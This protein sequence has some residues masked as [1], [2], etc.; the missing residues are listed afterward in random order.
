M[1]DFRWTDTGTTATDVTGK[2]ASRPTVRQQQATDQF[3]QQSDAAKDHE[4]NRHQE[5]HRMEERSR[6]EGGGS[7]RESDT[8]RNTR[9]TNRL[10]LVSYNIRHGRGM[11][12]QVNLSRTGDVLSRLDA[13]II[14]L[15][16]VDFRADRSGGVNQVVALGQQLQMYPAFAPFMEFQGGQYGIAILS[17]LPVVDSWTIPLPEGREPRAAVAIK[18]QLPDGQRVIAISVHFDWIGDDTARFAQATELL[19]VIGSYPEPVIVLGDYNDEPES[20][21]LD[22]FRQSGI[23]ADDTGATFRSDRL[24][25]RLDYITLFPRLFIE[26]SNPALS[27]TTESLVSWTV[28]A[29]RMISEPFASDHL[30]IVSEVDLDFSKTRG[31]ESR[32]ET[33]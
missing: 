22:L 27:S 32:C 31:M 28:L 20:R 2:K 13:D 19:K 33:K 15:Q 17:R 12:N 16:E 7:P 6:G 23:V 10:T 8:E 5:T 18:V 21:T 4:S 9:Q 25:K 11:D 26:P 30:P 24:S 1:T 29:S 3:D 14:A